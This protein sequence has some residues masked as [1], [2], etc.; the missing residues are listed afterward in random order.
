VGRAFLPGKEALMSAKQV[1]LAVDAANLAYSLE[2][3]ERLDF[4]ALLQFARGQGA[5]MEA[6]I[7]LAPARGID[8]D[9]GFLIDLKY[10]GYTR[11]VYRTPRRR[12]SGPPKSDVDIALAI[13]LWDAALRRPLDMVVLVS[14]DSDF[15]PI[16]ER[17][18]ERGV[19]V[20]VVGPSRAT[21]WELI[22]GSTQFVHASSVSGLISAAPQVAISLMDEALPG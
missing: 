16:V 10:M 6:A 9:R 1:Y 2:P 18:T 13:D 7:Y 11:V 4:G 17:L 22:V 14:G 3:G 15:L 20:A 8:R 21:A 5:L 19:E 12:P